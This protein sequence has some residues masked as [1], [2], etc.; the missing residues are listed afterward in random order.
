[1]NV[2]SLAIASLL[3][4]VVIAILSSLPLVSMGNC[5]VCMW[6]WGGGIFGAW[7]YW[8]SEKTVTPGQGAAVGFFS[9]LLAAILTTILSALIGVAGSGL[10]A[11]LEP[12]EDVLGSTIASLLMTGAWSIIG[13]LFNV[14]F[15]TIFGA[16]GGAIGGA[17]FG[18]QKAV[19]QDIEY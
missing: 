3:A 7:Y 19:V 1:M 2:R 5:L 15:F 8:R 12:A 11:V 6:V 4:G 10:A 17:I 13:L 16:I 14:F 9:G 18:R